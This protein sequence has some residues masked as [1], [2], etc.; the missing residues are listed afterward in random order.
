MSQT[1]P[2]T[3]LLQK[4]REGDAAALSALTPMIYQELHAVAV[5]LFRGERSNHTLQPTALVHEAYLRLVD[6]DVA[7]EDR[8]H[9]LRVAARAMRHLLVNYAG[10]FESLRNLFAFV[11]GV[12]LVVLLVTGLALR[13]YWQTRFMHSAHVRSIIAVL[14]GLLPA[15]GVFL[16]LIALL[17]EWPPPL[18]VKPSREGT[19]MGVSAKSIVHDESELREQISQI[20]D[21]LG[22]PN[23]MADNIAYLR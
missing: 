8:A 11:T 7:W 16:L 4:W 19:G 6:T 23:N 17:P 10:G 12:M 13:H 9:F 14:P 1:Q 18:F 2:V 22:L 20:L 15:G 3:E 5:R 21:T